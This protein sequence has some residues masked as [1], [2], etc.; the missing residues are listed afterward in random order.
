[1]RAFLL[2]LLLIGCG[3]SAPPLTDKQYCD[4]ACA[5]LI[6]CG[7]PYDM[8]CSTNC[9]TAAPV[10]LAC[11][12]TAV[13]DCNTLALC[14]FKQ[15]GAT[16]CGGNPGPTGSGT[17][18]GAASCEGACIG[19]GVATCPCSCIS[20]MSPTKAINLLIATQCAVSRCPAECGLTG[21]GI[22]CGVC[23]QQ[24]CPGENAQC[25]NN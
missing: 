11:V 9:Q 15:Y 7:V 20:G 4:N 21:S 13:M 17:C 5:T 16:N 25:S 6:S 19:S 3:E 8:T 1:M 12:K 22:A 23:V 14:T 18:N 2:G 10:F 24:K